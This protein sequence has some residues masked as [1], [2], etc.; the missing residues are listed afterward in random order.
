MS[1]SSGKL[2]SLSKNITELNV[3]S[4]DFMCPM[5][6][7]LGHNMNTF[8]FQTTDYV[9]KM[10]SYAY[11]FDKLESPNAYLKDIYLECL[12]GDRIYE[13][14]KRKLNYENANMSFQNIFKNRSAV[15]ASQ[16]RGLDLNSSKLYQSNINE[17]IYRSNPTNSFLNQQQM[18]LGS[19]RNEPPTQTQRPV[20]VRMT[21]KNPFDDS[22]DFFDDV[23]KPDKNKEN[24]Q[25]PFLENKGEKRF[26]DKSQGYRSFNPPVEA[27]MKETMRYSE[28]HEEPGPKKPS[29]A[30]VDDEFDECKPS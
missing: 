16:T 17:E 24:I 20:E 15:Y 27:H 26:Q 7:A 11:S 6:S 5:L 25:G 18:L 29:N 2:S 4:I 14:Q 22:K 23:P 10:D 8:H 19:I 12:F 13:S 30:V 28:A 1:L 3:R 21:N 9:K